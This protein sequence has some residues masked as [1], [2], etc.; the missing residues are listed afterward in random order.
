MSAAV[1]PR[2]ARA[3]ARSSDAEGVQPCTAAQLRWRLACRAG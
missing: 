1:Q 2:L 3:E